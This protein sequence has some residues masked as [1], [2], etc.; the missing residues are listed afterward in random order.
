VF[1]LRYHVAS[2][3][4]VF[5]ALAV[6]IL[7]GVAISGKVSDAEE[8]LQQERRQQ[9]EEDLEE[10]NARADA[11]GR[12]GEAAEEVVEGAYPALME[13]RLEDAGVAVAFLGPVDGT[14]RAEVER[15]LSDADSGSPER[16]VALDVPVDAL[17]LQNRLEGDEVL[18][19]YAGERGDF[20]ALGEEL[21]SEL[22]EGG[23]TPLWRALQSELVEERSGDT[24]PEVDGAVVVASWRPEA[25]EGD[26]D[27]DAEAESRATTTL[28]DGIV[29][30]LESSG[31]PVVGV[32]TTDQPSEL[33]EIYR[34]RGISSVD[35]VDTPAG[36]L[37]LALLLAGAEPGHYGVKD[38]AADGVVPPFDSL[39]EQS[40]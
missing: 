21:G 4:A 12:S 37:A 40:E 34:T 19:S 33:S 27:A 6:G 2:L 10:A 29:R 32:A 1:G 35:D 18:A 20:S 11:A 9:L 15:A 30:G 16:V 7:L 17:E 36:R 38:T 39:P 13:G 8:S 3:A 23:E 31:R 22:A 24:S 25:S 14:I 26:G 28:M 5:L